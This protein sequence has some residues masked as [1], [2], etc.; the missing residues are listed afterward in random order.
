ML[1][2][3]NIVVDVADNILDQLFNI[4]SMNSTQ[5]IFACVTIDSG[6]HR[7]IVD[8]GSSVL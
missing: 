5:P 1:K 2:Q 6:T 4:D 7:F 3:A 8:S